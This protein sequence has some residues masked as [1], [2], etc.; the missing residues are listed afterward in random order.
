MDLV[1]AGARW[2]RG[3]E[4]STPPLR[5]RHEWTDGQPSPARARETRVCRSR[6]LQT[7]DDYAVERSLERA[8]TR[9]Y[10][11]ESTVEEAPSPRSPSS[12]LPSVM[13][14]RGGHRFTDPYPTLTVGRSIS[15]RGLVPRRPA[16][17]AVVGREGTSPSPTGRGRELTRRWGGLRAFGK[18]VITRPKQ[19]HPIPHGRNQLG[20]RDPRLS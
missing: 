9:G 7:D 6:Q 3:G 19:S 2:H 16:P 10:Q 1:S 17:W 13:K 20:G 15:G 12:S 11:V 14:G 4:S 8:K 18:G 5:W